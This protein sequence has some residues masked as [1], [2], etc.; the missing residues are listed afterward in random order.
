MI[1]RNASGRKIWDCQEKSQVR[2]NCIEVTKI[3]VTRLDFS[4]RNPP[5]KHQDNYVDFIVI[6]T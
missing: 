5:K 3:E 2:P 6:L 4:G 1:F